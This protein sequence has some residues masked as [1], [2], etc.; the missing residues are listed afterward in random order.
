MMKYQTVKGMRNIFGAEAAEFNLIEKKSADIFLKY[1]YSPIRIPVVEQSAL[2]TRSI[3]EATDIVEKEMYA[4]QDKGGRNL[5]L[6]PEGTAGVVKAYIEE[7]L[8]QKFPSQKF[9]YSG[10]MFRQERP[11]AGRYREFTQVGCEYFGNASVYADVEVIALACEILDSIG[12]RG[13]EVRL[14]SIGCEKCRPSFISAVKEK[15]KL[16]YNDL[17]EDCRRRSDKNPLRA[18]DCKIDGGKFSDVGIKLCDECARDFENLKSGL[19]EAGV[20]F[21]VTNTLVRGLDYYT[22]TVFEIVSGALGSQNAVCAGGRYNNLVADLGGPPTPAVG[23]AFGVD[24]L[25]GILKPA[26]GAPAGNTGVFVAAFGGVQVLNYA[27]G[28]LKK[29]R[30]SGVPSDGGYFSKSIKSQMRQADALNSGYVIIVGEDELKN[31]TLALKNMK[32]KE[33]KTLAIKDIDAE[34]GR[35]PK[36]V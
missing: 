22:K 9:F 32:T 24:R 6:R 27:F 5:A 29:L 25:A 33:Q 17:C 28:V 7:N 35:L 30:D 31:G 12:V 26:E 3:G 19:A 23:F 2:F 10:N 16:S 18:L 15:L 11:Q 21:E 1:N 13:A 36:S 8:A 34:I 20:K 4:F 14:N